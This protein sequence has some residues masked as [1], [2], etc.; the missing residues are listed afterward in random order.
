[1]LEKLNDGWRVTEMHLEVLADIPNTSFEIFEGAANEAKTN[2][3]ISRLLNTK[4]TMN[5]KLKQIAA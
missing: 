5:A 3:P 1:M 4:I 2:C